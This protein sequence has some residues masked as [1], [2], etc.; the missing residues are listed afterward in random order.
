MAKN[1]KPKGYWTKARCAEEALKYDTLTAF[2]KGAS[3]AYQAAHRN[4]WLDD[5]CDHMTSTQ[6]PKGY[7]TKQRCKAE[8]LKYETRSSFA[9]GSKSAYH[10]A[11][12]AGW[13]DD[14]CDHMTSRTKPSGYWTKQRCKAEALKYET[15][16][17]F[18]KGSNSAYNAAQKNKWLDEICSH[19]GY[20]P[21]KATSECSREEYNK[22][23]KQY[24]DDKIDFMKNELE[25]FWYGYQKGWNKE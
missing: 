15:R 21:I 12:Q 25:L 22:A 13:L 2:R 20:K 19:M 1:Y 23:R 24:G 11:Q 6:K 18:Q 4:K 14:I 17:A 8:A 3:T 9:K 16:I 7:W 5:I 10:A